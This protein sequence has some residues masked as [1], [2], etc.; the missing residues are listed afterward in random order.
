MPGN[1]ATDGFLIQ[2]VREERML[3][4]EKEKQGFVKMEI[5][6]LVAGAGVTDIS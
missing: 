6:L 5:N 2:A 3:K 4:S 1:V